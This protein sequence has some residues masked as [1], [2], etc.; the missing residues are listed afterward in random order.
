M[1][2]PKTVPLLPGFQFSDPYKQNFHKTQQFQHVNATN[3]EKENYI[4]ESV[5]TGLVKDMRLNTPPD[6][7]YG[8]KP[9]PINSHLPRIPPAWL[10]YDRKVLQF[11]AYFQE[12][13]VENKN[14]NYRLRKCIIYFYLT[15]ATIYVT[16][17][18]IENSGIPQGVFIK[19]QKV[20]RTLTNK[21][22]FYDWKDF[23]LG[24]SMNFFERVFRVVNCDEFTRAFFLENGVQLSSPEPMPVDS[25]DI[26][27]SLKDMKIPPP[28]T[29]EYKEY[30]EVK[31]GGGHPN[32]GLHKYL[33]NDR[34]VLSF[35]IVWEDRSLEGGLNFFKMNFFLADDTVEV[36]EVRQQNSGKDPFPLLLRRSKIPKNPVLT[37]Y[38]GMNLKK[39]E[40]YSYQDLVIGKVIQIFGRECLIFNCDEFTK[41][42]YRDVCNIDQVPIDLQK[43]P[44]RKFMQPIPPY[45]GY[46]TEED[47]LGSVF[48]LNPKPPRKDVNKIFTND[49]YI[50]RFEGR[51]I[52]ENKDDNHRKFIVSLFCGDDTIQV[53]EQAERN[54]GIWA[55]KFL[56]RRQ[57]KH[58]VTGEYYTAK[59][60]MI[61][62]IV[63]LANYKFQLL[64]ADEFTHRFMVENPGIFKE[65]DLDKVIEKLILNGKKYKNNEEYGVKLFQVLDKKKKGK[66][67]FVDLYDGLKELGIPL[68]IHEQYTLMRRF[69]DR[70][71]EFKMNMD[72]FYKGI[73]VVKRQ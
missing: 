19:R 23:D 29:K 10:K 16:E 48:S 43:N 49:M 39:E 50:L 31:L 42:W 70:S 1:N 61:G 66:I 53:Y 37:H 62:E 24:V 18:K 59:D 73:F 67:E 15:D 63:T 17:P 55:G 28:D 72:D 71:G 14:E 36:K 40:Y 2:L 26:I 32:N 7:T 8:E 30:F 65:A 44:P 34:K 11:D 69:G 4:K 21:Y 58:P 12:H 47:S 54:S 9:E 27:K 3:L 38:P 13:V 45:N 52:S 41:A 57:H 5:D 25:F 60:M 6:L 68:T 22:D 33:E 64:K 46:G 35:D 20:P 51:M 56:E